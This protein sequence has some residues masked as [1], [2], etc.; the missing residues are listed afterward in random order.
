MTL[1]THPFEAPAQALQAD[2]LVIGGG[3]AGAWSALSARAAGAER[4]VLV[5]K[6][7]CGTSGATASANTGVWC[8]APE[9]DA[10]ERAIANRAAQSGGLGRPGTMASVLETTWE[11]LSLL[12]EWG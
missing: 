5:D 9:G 1:T 11:R 12:A 3:P 8:V 10:R 7:Y 6:G 4:V 2:V